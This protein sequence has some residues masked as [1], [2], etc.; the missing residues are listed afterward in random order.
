[1]PSELASLTHLATL[2]LNESRALTG[3][4][5]DGLRELADLETVNIQHTELCAPE[6]DT[7][8]SWLEYHHL[9]RPDLPPCRA[10]G[11]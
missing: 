7:F 10:V 1:M 9:Q 11:D 8:Q 6:D 2:L 3:H 5:P 4:L